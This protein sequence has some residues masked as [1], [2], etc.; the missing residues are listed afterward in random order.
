MLRL[1][2]PLIVL[3]LGAP[4]S[5][6]AVE[7]IHYQNKPVT[8]HLQS[9]V[10]RT[11][12][13]GDHVQVGVTPKQEM[14]RL[15]RIQSAQG[16]VHIKPHSDFESERIQL[17]RMSD[18]QIVLL[19]LI[20][21]PAEPEEGPLE[22][23]RLYVQ[24]EGEDDQFNTDHVATSLDDKVSA[25][26]AVTPITLTRYVAQKLYAPTRLHKDD[27]R[28]TPVNL[29]ELRGQPIR[30]FTGQ[31]SVTTESVPVLA[32]RSGRYHIAAILIR[33]TRFQ[34]V[35]LNYLNLNLPFSHATYQHH[36]LQPM[37]RQ[38]DRTM[39]YLVSERSM[40]ETLVPWN[41]YS[42]RESAEPKEQ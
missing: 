25:V 10:E 4:L 37:G 36:T 22:S 5:A 17:R 18:G 27:A 11:I 32:Y 9:G 31:A 7:I 8:I 13:L 20:S 16:A 15:F 19:D 24:G 2:T 30:V 28:I 21:K 14:S 38:G 34:P 12:Q 29:S 6:Q 41:Y 35:Q 42:D 3:A 26:E 39:L 1:I 40:K 33:N 23:V